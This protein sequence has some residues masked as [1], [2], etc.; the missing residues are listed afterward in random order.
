M[1]RT[2]QMPLVQYSTQYITH[3]TQQIYGI[4]HTVNI[5]AQ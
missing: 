2:F 3:F 1:L 4:L 5:S